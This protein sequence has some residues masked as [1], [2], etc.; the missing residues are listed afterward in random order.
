VT[1]RRLAR[2]VRNACWSPGARL[3]GV[4]FSWDYLRLAWRA[5]RRWGDEA[6]GTFNLLGWRVAYPRGTHALF[7]VHEL[8][9]NGAYAFDATQRNPRIIDAGANIGLSVLFFK[10]RYPDARILAIEPEPG[11]FAHLQ[12]V[13]ATNGLGDVALVN[14]AVGDPPGVAVFYSDPDTGGSISASL[15]PALGGA[16]RQEVPVVRLSTLIDGPVDFLKLDV[17]GAEYAVVRDLIA[18][19]QIA[20][21]REAVIEYHPVATE[22]DEPANLM[23]ALREA[24]MTVE[25]EST[26]AG[27]RTGV[28]RARRAPA[29]R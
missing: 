6:P 28:L 9:V 21:V 17:E 29:P 22:P 12:R 24:G 1:I 23:R 15:V 7:L 13:L 18:T 2:A 4:R 14:V 19:G 11:T 10:S 27:A 5:Q 25:V 8:F 3:F 20:L 16:Q 26:N